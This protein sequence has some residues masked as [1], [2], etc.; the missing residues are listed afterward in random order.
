MDF[1]ESGYFFLSGSADG[2]MIL[3]K[4]DEPHPQRIYNHKGDVYKVKFSKDPSF[5]ISGGED[6]CIKIWKT[7]NA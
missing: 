4:T 5:V 2:W 7:I 1:S 6:G 3:W